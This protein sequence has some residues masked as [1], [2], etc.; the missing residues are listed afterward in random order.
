MEFKYIC[1]VTDQIIQSTLDFIIFFSVKWEEQTI[2]IMCIL[3]NLNSE[4]LGKRCPH[5]AGC[6]GR[7]KLHESKLPHACLLG[8]LTS[9]DQRDEWTIIGLMT[10]LWQMTLYGNILSVPNHISDVLHNLQFTGPG[11]R[12]LTHIW[13]D[14]LHK[15]QIQ[16]R[17][18][19]AMTISGH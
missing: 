6:W 19:L 10:N 16:W 4:P 5:N 3:Q 12:I 9:V 15:I 13:A 2:F 14:A 17:S 7:K 11:I 1:F 18:W 8:T